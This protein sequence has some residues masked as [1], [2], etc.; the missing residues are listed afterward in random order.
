MIAGV[1]IIM[2]DTNEL[3]LADVSEVVINELAWA[4][5][6]L[7]AQDEWIEL[8]N[9]TDTEIDISGWQLTKNTGEEQLMITIPEGSSVPP[10]GYFLISNYPAGES[11]LAIEPDL[12]DSSITL[13][14]SNLQIKLY[15]GDWTQVE[16]LVDTAGDGGD[17][18]V[19]GGDNLMKSS[20]ERDSDYTGWHSALVAVNLDVG[21]SDPDLGT[22]AAANSIPIPPPTLESVF[23]TETE[24]TDIFEV[25]E[26]QGTNF[27]VDPVPT[28]QLVLDSQTVNG[29][30]VSVV[31]GTL[32]DYVEFNIDNAETGEWDLVLINPDGKSA[33]LPNAITILEPKPEYDL[34]TTV[35][36]NEIY[37]KPSTTSN[38][39]FI[40]LYNFGDKAVNLTG[41]QLDDV[42]N[43]GSNPHTFTGVI[44]N[45]Q[46]FVVIHKPASKITLN[47]N[48]DSVYL[49][50]PG[51][52]VLDQV[53]YEGAERGETLSRF[54]EGWQWTETPTPNG[55]N[56]LTET[57]E[58]PPPTEDFEPD[59]ESADEPAT[60][61]KV[62]YEPGDVL[63]TEIL[64]NPDGEEEFIELFNNSGESID[65]GGWQ[66]QDAS[67]KTHTINDFNVAV[68][69]TGG[70]EPGEYIFIT[71]SVSKLYLNNTGGEELWLQDPSGTIIDDVSYP[72]RAPLGAAYAFDLGGEYWTWTETPTPGEDNVIILAED[73]E[74]VLGDTDESYL[75]A[76]VSSGPETWRWAGIAIVSLALTAMLFWYWEE[77]YATKSSSR[78]HRFIKNPPAG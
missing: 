68:Q 43:G 20:M 56:V 69:A 34:T 72:D 51:G 4:G 71:Q 63:I 24:P 74:E 21:P 25:E 42:R 50:Q 62:E 19:L 33:I 23:P 46:S 45:S 58:E 15:S 67:G 14:N 5:S 39:E 37:P 6:S 61:S 11:V 16:N 41:W 48:G 59:D 73:E 52:F 26:I 36:I 49:L 78:Y 18:K 31:D 17:P 60:E 3:A 76:L 10:G 7:S 32:I 55:M 1:G 44:I 29:S 57:T 30:G 12:V 13:S 65:I 75:S 27:S 77:R 28:I 53:A 47:D 35:R 66:I 8:K 40:E 9:T 70:M 38:D 2:S 22:P 54:A 64:P